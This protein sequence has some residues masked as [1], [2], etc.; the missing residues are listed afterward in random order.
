MQELNRMCNDCLCLGNDC[1]GSTNHTWTGCALKRQ[2]AKNIWEDN[3]HRIGF[4]R[5]E[6]EEKNV[7]VSKLKE[8][9]IQTY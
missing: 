4:S 1:K 6:L 8:V 9:A 5:E 2:D 7:C 3:S